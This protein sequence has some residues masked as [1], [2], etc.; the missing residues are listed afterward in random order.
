[1][2]G[3]VS[4]GTRLRLVGDA[5]D[6]FALGVQGVVI[7]PTAGDHQS[8]S[9]ED[10]VAVRPDLILDVRP[11]VLRITANVGA[12]LRKDHRVLGAHIRDELVY[13]L[14]LGVPLHAR[15]ELLGELSGAFSFQDF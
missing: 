10:S 15:F 6:V 13:G 11:K 9:G 7:V 2:F 4:A 5:D 12:L 14:A 1:G 8:Y 3:D